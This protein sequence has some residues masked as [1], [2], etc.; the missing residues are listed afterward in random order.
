MLV[1]ALETF[2][3]SCQYKGSLR[4]GE[5]GTGIFVIKTIRFVKIR[6]R[7][8]GYITL[9][10]T[11]GEFRVTGPVHCEDCGKLILIKYH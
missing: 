6:C 1:L 9:I 2:V 4:K 8:C 5:D 10:P 3:L 7:T 11:Y